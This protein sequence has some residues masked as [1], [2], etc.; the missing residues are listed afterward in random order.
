MINPTWTTE[1]KRGNKYEEPL[2]SMLTVENL[3]WLRDKPNGVT[4]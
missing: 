2:D 1:I 4:C 3:D